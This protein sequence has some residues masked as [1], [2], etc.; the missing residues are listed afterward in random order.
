MICSSQ[1]E[2]VQAIRAVQ[3]WMWL[4]FLEGLVSQF[5]VIEGDVAMLRAAV[6]SSQMDDVVSS[7]ATA[8]G[9][10]EG[11]SHL[12]TPAVVVTAAYDV[13]AAATAEGVTF[14]G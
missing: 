3:R 8:E 6:R 5:G 7:A 14:R 1:M 9:V 12:V 11:V 2:Q 13:V 4:V 10:I